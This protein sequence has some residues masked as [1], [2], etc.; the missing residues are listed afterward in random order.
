MTDPLNKSDRRKEERKIADDIIRWKRPGKIEDQKA[1]MVDRAPSG[2]GFLTNTE[3]APCVGEVLN[4]R[5]LDRDRWITIDRTVRVARAAL[6]SDDSL[7]MIGCA[8]E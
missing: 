7:T 4:V 6:A 8:V 5:Q 3:I 2:L 1:W